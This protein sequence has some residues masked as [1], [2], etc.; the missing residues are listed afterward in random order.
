M[1]IMSVT[2]RSH[3]PYAQLDSCGV[4][5]A[6]VSGSGS[7]RG[8]KNKEKRIEKRHREREREEGKGNGS[9]V[10]SFVIISLEPKVSLARP[11][12]SGR[13]KEGEGE[14]EREQAEATKK[15]T[16]YV[17]DDVVKCAYNGDDK[18]ERETASMAACR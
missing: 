9:C 11:D 2:G 5:K 16:A 4:L 7:G 17:T 13:A 8:K 15:H 10:N 1:E 12:W 6:P 14:G 3:A 18:D